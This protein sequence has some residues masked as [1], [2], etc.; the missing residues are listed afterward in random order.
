MSEFRKNYIMFLIGWITKSDLSDFKT[1]EQF[2]EQVCLH[3]DFI[4]KGTNQPQLTTDEKNYFD[5]VNSWV[6]QMS[7]TL[8][9][10]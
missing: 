5:V 4:L 8:L 1:I 9:E 3:I 10:F 6:R 2:K 7:N